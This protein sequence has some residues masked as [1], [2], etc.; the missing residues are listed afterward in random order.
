MASSILKSTVITNRDALPRVANNNRLS[1]AHK[2][3]ATGFVTSLAADDTNSRYRLVAVPSNAIIRGI[4]LGSV[5]QGAGAV[6][7]GVY[8]NTADGGAAVSASLFAAAFSV[9]AAVARSDVTNQAGT[10]TFSLREQ[11]LWQAAGLAA[12]PLSDLDIVVAPSTTF[13]NGGQ[14]GIEVE[15]VV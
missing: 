14:I 10:Y 4:Y 12:D 6:N 8:R 9:A 7:V 5:A 3:T 11:P 2:R 15:Y 1:N 13:T